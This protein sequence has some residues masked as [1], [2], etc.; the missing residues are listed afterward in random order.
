MSPRRC[1]PARARHAAS[2]PHAFGARR[3]ISST[4]ARRRSRG[5]ASWSGALDAG[6]WAAAAHARGAED[7]PGA[8]RARGVPLCYSREGVRPCA[9]QGR[10]AAC[11]G[12]CAC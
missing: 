10:G 12:V 3:T 8:A 2:G 9:G 6:G 1:R 5:G 4:T 11:P 7:V